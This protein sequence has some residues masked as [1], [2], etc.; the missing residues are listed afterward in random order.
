MEIAEARREVRTCDGERRERPQLEPASRVG[1]TNLKNGCDGVLL[2]LSCLEQGRKRWRRRRV[3]SMATRKGTSAS[4]PSPISSD[5]PPPLK[6]PPEAH[7]PHLNCIRDSGQHVGRRTETKEPCS[8][9]DEVSNLLGSHTEV[10]LACPP[11]ELLLLLLQGRARDRR[12]S[13][14]GIL[15]CV[16]VDCYRGI[17]S[18]S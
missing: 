8:R 5:L 14:V 9:S 12:K 2:E 17:R 11:L 3:S 7:Q 18:S 6:H 10:E 16:L 1:S 4:S 15:S 13:C